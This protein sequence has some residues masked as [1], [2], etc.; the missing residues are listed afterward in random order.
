MGQ[1]PAGQET[2]AVSVTRATSMEG[3]LWVFLCRAP[4]IEICKIHEPCCFQGQ[5]LTQKLS[6]ANGNNSYSSLEDEDQEGRPPGG[7]GT[8]AKWCQIKQESGK[9][10][11]KKKSLRSGHEVPEYRRLWPDTGKSRAMEN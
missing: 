5:G 3:F 7:G 6:K 8:Q 4:R 10:R 2:A 9:E 1:C 11:R